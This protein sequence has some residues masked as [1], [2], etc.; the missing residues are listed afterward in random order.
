MTRKLLWVVAACAAVLL[1]TGCGSKNKTAASSAGQKIFVGSGCGG[2]HS[3]AAA[4]SSG[5]VGPNLDQLEPSFK[6]VARQVRLGGNGMPAFASR[7]SKGEIDDVATFVSQSADKNK[8]AVV[9]F[10]PDKTKI[11]D[12]SDAPCYQQ[13]FGNIAFRQG[14]E[15]ALA[16]LDKDSR[17]MHT[18][19]VECHP[20]SH[21]IGHAGLARYHGN[22]AQALG[23]GGMT[24]ASGYYHGVIEIAFAGVP[25]S[26]V[27][28][29]ARRMCSGS[30]IRAKEF[31]AYQCVHGLGH[32]LMV[33][34]RDD[35]P[36][37]LRVCERLETGWD[38]TSCDG[39]VFMQNVVP[40]MG[41]RSK[42]LKANDLIYPCNWVA[43]R[44]KL[45]CYL[46]A[47]SRILPAVKFNWTKAAAWCRKSEPGWVA[48][49][50]QSYG[51]D[52]SGST[53]LNARKTNAICLRAGSMAGECFYGAARDFANTDA[54]GRRASLLCRIAPERYR[55]QCFEGVGSILG[56]LNTYGPQRRAACKAV[57]PKRYLRA[58]L[59][60][61]AVV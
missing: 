5:Q 34:S 36:Y 47:T 11:A 10:T 12:C 13:A 46:L 17:K 30:D 33:Y 55:V 53:Q 45:Y 61:A 20:I 18:V 29:K 8:T 49:C 31:I 25:R 59:R 28:G 58:C 56:S 15:K 44:H 2:C 23:H 6:R 50:F 27:S 4:K 24:C 35:L 16:L 1:V 21:A 42:W 37:S 41:L 40:T 43:R 57:T 26:K 52:A 32:G 22:A 3:L 7:L 54:N 60:G 38:Q 39:G 14:P 19:T 51:R 48:T 9:K